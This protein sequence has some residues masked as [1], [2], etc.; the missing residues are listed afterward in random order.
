MWNS[1]KHEGHLGRVAP[2]CYTPISMLK[3]EAFLWEILEDTTSLYQ[4]FWVTVSND[5]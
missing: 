3:N 5:I 4:V 1:E 2:A